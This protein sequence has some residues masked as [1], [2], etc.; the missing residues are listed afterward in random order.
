LILANVSTSGFTCGIILDITYNIS[1]DFPPVISIDPFR[2]QQIAGNLLNNAIKYTERGSINCKVEWKTT[3]KNDGYI[4]FK[5]QDTGIGIPKEQHDNIFNEFYQ[6]GAKGNTAS[7]DGVGLGLSIVKQLV[8][9][10]N[11]KIHLE[12]QVGQGTT[13]TVIIPA[14]ILEDKVGNLFHEDPTITNQNISEIRVL[15]AEDNTIIRRLI[16]TYLINKKFHIDTAVNGK[17]AVEYFT[18][19]NYDFVLL[20]INMPVMNGYD[21]AKAIRTAIEKTDHLTNTKIIALSA[22]VVVSEEE[23]KRLQNFDDFILKPVE[24]P[25]LVKYLQD[26]FFKNLKK[27]NNNSQNALLEDKPREFLDDPELS[28]DL[29]MKIV[30]MLVKELEKETLKISEFTQKSDITNIMY[31]LHHLK[32]S[33]GILRLNKTLNTIE[34]IE[35]DLKADATITA[36]TLVN[37]NKLNERILSTRNFLIQ[38]THYVK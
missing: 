13:F 2:L 19:Y 32:S 34:L 25:W 15:I 36:Q 12:S 5:I 27:Q 16:A 17:E 10:F 33:A 11:G 3:N 38:N 23:K 28:N 37:I 26:D 8:D 24:L 29:K 20:D 18:K 31:Q 22:S 21:A 9:A 1:P 7:H 14:M 30:I 4:I 6:L 35:S